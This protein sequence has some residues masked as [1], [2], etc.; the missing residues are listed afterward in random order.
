M[1]TTS[2]LG[3]RWYD[4][5]SDV[6]W[7]KYGGCWGRPMPTPDEPDLWAVI[8][9]DTTVLG[10]HAVAVHVRESNAT[11]EE[12]SYADVPLDGLDEW[13]KPLPPLEWAADRVRA[14][15]YYWGANGVA[16]GEVFFCH[17]ADMARAAAARYLT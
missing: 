17:R 10:S 11:R 13:G 5:G 14:Y 1:K 15:I 6:G 4:L 3:K 7:Q 12:M 16:G 2:I 9:L 8:R